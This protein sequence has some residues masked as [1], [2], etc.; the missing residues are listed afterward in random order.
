MKASAYFDWDVERQNERDGVTV[1]CGHMVCRRPHQSQLSLAETALFKAMNERW[2]VDSTL[3]VGVA[4]T[5]ED[6]EYDAKTGRVIASIRAE[7]NANRQYRQK[8]AELLKKADEFVMAVKRDLCLLDE[9][10]KALKHQLS[11]HAEEKSDE[12]EG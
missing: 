6:D 8:V 2:D 5:H 10:H 4:T 11:A 1:V 7:A 3:T 12:Q 9:R